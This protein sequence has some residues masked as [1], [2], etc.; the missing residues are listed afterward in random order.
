MST[1]LL[2]GGVMLVVGL[3]CADRAKPVRAADAPPAD[4]LVATAR[5][6]AEIWW[7]LARHDSAG[8]RRCI[9]RAVEIRR[10]TARIPVPLLYTTLVPEVLDDTTARARL[11]THCLAGDSYLVDL[12]S[13][14]PVR[15]RS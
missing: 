11:S 14:R 7:T 6:G 10:G 3:G 13:G 12:R 15:E 4:T 5:G 8:G 2:A 1:R 9:E